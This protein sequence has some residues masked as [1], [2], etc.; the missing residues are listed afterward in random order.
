[1]LTIDGNNAIIHTTRGGEI[2][3]FLS[4]AKVDGDQLIVP[5]THENAHACIMQGL[6]Y[7]HPI[8]LEPAST[9]HGP[10]PPAAHQ[11]GMMNFFCAAQRGYLLAD[12]GTMKTATAVWAA[13]YL[14]KRGIINR[15]L[16]V[17]PL[18]ILDDTW[19]RALFECAMGTPFT[20]VYGRTPA[21]K[22]K[23]LAEK[24][25]WHV[26]NFDG[27]VSMLAQMKSIPY[28]CI[29]V[30]ESRTYASNTTDRWKAL[31][32][33]TKKANIVIGLTG[34]AT[35]QGP[36][37][38]YGQAKLITPA[39]M[40]YNKREWQ[41]LTMQEVRKFKWTPRPEAVVHIASAM[42]PSYVVRK[43]E[44]LK[45]L[46]PLTKEFE[47]VEMTAMQ[48]EAL[49]ILR[50]HSMLEFEGGMV[51]PANAGVKFSKMLQVASGCLYS[52]DHTA[53]EFDA[54]PRIE[55]ALRWYESAAS[56]TLIF[57][58][59]VHTIRMLA[60]VFE[61]LGFAVITGDTPARERGRI[62][63]AFTDGAYKGILAQP[64]CMSH[65]VNAQKADVTV[66]F[67]P[68]PSTDIY[69]QA[70]NRMDRPG[71]RHPM[72]MVHLYSTAQEKERYNQIAQNLAN[73]DN[74]FQLFKRFI[75][76]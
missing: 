50:K 69:T 12:M 70:S 10:W 73:Q 67:S 36:M 18:T 66:W 42:Y 38:A 23:L 9:F 74:T 62:I 56:G 20:I 15:V 76:E 7:A 41:N 8:L 29:I 28:D 64:S 14:R 30:D 26:T 49:A 68:P 58:T 45:D 17:A 72:T 60:K 51:T 54:T 32:Q 1:M 59:F 39:T 57:A 65:G 4:G 2:A 52:D 61:P 27:V 75:D 35:P 5:I 21:I 55:A 37:D 6:P 33:L 40:Q 24:T 31:N 53:W 13:E 3:G 71:Q 44:V 43:R 46:P 63:S 48:K 16:V 25:A 19:G 34:A 22:A 47:Q 11:Y